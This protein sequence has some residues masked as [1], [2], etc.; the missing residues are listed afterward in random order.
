MV[1]LLS[2]L[3]SSLPNHIWDSK[4]LLSFCFPF[5]T[6]EG[7][8]KIFLCFALVCRPL[9]ENKSCWMIIR[10]RM[11]S[12]AAENVLCLCKSIKLV[13]LRFISPFFRCILSLWVLRSRRNTSRVVVYYHRGLHCLCLILPLEGA[14]KTFNK[15]LSTF[16]REIIS[17]SKIAK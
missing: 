15:R 5:L 3:F 14:T 10:S 16:L 2:R 17:L 4:L 1:S 6:F 7:E 8:A 9:K 11:G 12:A 13:L